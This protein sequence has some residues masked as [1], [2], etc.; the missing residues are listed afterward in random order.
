MTSGAPLLFTH[1]EAG[2]AR[3]VRSRLVRSAPDPVSPRPVGG[4]VR[5]SG[6]GP[7]QAGMAWGRGAGTAFP[8]SCASTSS[9][10]SA[11]RAG[12][13]WCGMGRLWRGRVQTPVR[14]G[15]PRGA[16]AAGLMPTRVSP[17]TPTPRLFLWLPV[18]A[19]PAGACGGG[20]AGGGSVPRRG[21]GLW[22]LD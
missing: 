3:L 10:E 16:A 11:R 13:H 9:P 14:A 21:S 17:L 8:G 2:A 7:G 6:P 22:A 1:S 20:G 18:A 19:Q 5:R 15:D 12:G 4:E